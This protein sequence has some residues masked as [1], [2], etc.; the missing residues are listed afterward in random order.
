MLLG[1]SHV[2]MYADDLA[3]AAKWYQDT[4]GFKLRFLDAKHYGMLHHDGM[5]FDLHLHP[6]RPDARGGKPGVGG[7]IYFFTDNI[8]MEVDALRAKGVSIDK[9]RSEG[10]SPRFSSFRDSEGNELG[11]SEKKA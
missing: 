4:L 8:D 1:F 9:P 3:R 2:M 7:Q 10:G 5:K 11:L 6:N